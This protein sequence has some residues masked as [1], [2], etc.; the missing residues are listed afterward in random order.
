[1]MLLINASLWVW[2]L[3]RNAGAA[4]TTC[5]GSFSHA[6]YLTALSVFV[7]EWVHNIV[8]TIPKPGGGLQYVREWQQFW[9]PSWTLSGDFFPYAVAPRLLIAC[10]VVLLY[11]S[12]TLWYHRA[13]SAG[14]RSGDLLTIPTAPSGCPLA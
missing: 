13:R 1:M 4:L 8:R 14:P 7:P 5:V 11:L 9:M 2:W 3:D 6:I 12:W 10:V